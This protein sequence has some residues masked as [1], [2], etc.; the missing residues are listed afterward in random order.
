MNDYLADRRR[1]LYGAKEGTAQQYGGYD[2]D[3]LFAFFQGNRPI[4]P[5][6]PTRILRVN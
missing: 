3:A 5:L 6:P 4:G 2:V 1:R